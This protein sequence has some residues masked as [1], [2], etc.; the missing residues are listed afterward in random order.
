MPIFMGQCTVENRMK[1]LKMAKEF[2][3]EPNDGKDYV[4]HYETML[5][6]IENSPEIQKEAVIKTVADAIESDEII[7]EAIE[8]IIGSRRIEEDE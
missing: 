3:S 8:N 1:L 2:A 5:G 4:E 6:L 7:R